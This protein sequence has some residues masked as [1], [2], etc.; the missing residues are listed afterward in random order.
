MSH[1]AP[2][3]PT[4]EAELLERCRAIA[5]LSLQQ[6]ADHYAVT[7]PEDLRRHKGWVGQLVELA[8]G[9]DAQ[10]LA[11]PDFRTIGVEL[12]TLPLDGNGQ[13]REST[14]VCTVPL[15]DGLEPDWESSWVCRKLSRVLWLPVEADPAIPLGQRRI[16]TALLWCP[17][18]S[19]QALLRQD[20]EEFSEMICMGE[21]ERITARLGQVL[22]I[23]P[24]AAN[25]RVRCRSVGAGGE[26]ILT[27]PRG[28]Y[29]RPAFTRT[30]LQ[31][32][33]HSD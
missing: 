1:L 23:R 28:Y 6:L 2:S 32:H 21:L 22:Q 27:N 9:A 14:Y 8:L 4:S 16:G 20:W 29:L 18:E 7:V 19:E 26:S 17:D 15:D 13:P 30:L 12:K 3:P 24:K 31:R 33:Y 11:E 25:S 5:G 10:S